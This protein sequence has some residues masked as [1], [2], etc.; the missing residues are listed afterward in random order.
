MW[1]S[2][3]YSPAVICMY[4]IIDV[5]TYTCIYVCMWGSHGYSPAVIHMYRIIDVYMYVFGV[6]VAI[7][8]Q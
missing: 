3:G 5:Y 4:R 2:R 8:P 7:H 6:P 1:I